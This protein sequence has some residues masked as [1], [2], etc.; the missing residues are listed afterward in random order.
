MS[1]INK[2]RLEVQTILRECLIEG[3][4]RLGLPAEGAD[5]WTIQ[6]FANADFTNGDKL[7]LLNMIREG[8]A[9]WQFSSQEKFAVDG[10]VD[11]YQNRCS[12]QT[13]QIHF[14]A[15]FKYSQDDDL[16]AMDMANKMKFWLNGPGIDFL[17]KRGIS[18]FR[19][20]NDDVIVY[21]DDS[22]LYQKRAV[23][24]VKLNV[25]QKELFKEKIIENLIPGIYPE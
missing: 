13:W 14:I 7:I 1:E 8:L 18:L 23:V 17:R 19:I 16:F 21:N 5:A 22:E 24:N 10:L 11:V 6:E 3:M 25:P 20:D 15:K 9:G 12:L 2:T 4:S